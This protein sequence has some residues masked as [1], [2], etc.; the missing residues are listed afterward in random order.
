MFNISIV[1]RT[2]LYMLLRGLV[3]VFKEFIAG[4]GQCS[5]QNDKLLEV[6][7]TVLVLIQVIHDLLNHRG[8]IAG[9][10]QKHRE[11]NRTKDQI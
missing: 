10:Q 4:N 8:I 5:D 9:L 1:W 2:E 11:E 7:F 3:T 6:Y